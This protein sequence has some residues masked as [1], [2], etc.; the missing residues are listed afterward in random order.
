V[1]YRTCPDALKHTPGE[2]GAS[3]A[4][5]PAAPNDAATLASPGGAS[6][7]TPAEPASEGRQKRVHRTNNR[8]SKGSS[9][10]SSSRSRSSSRSSRRRGREQG[11]QQAVPLAG[12]L[13]NE[14][15]A[16]FITEALLQEIRQVSGSTSKVRPVYCFMVFTRT[17]HCR[18]SQMSHLL[19]SH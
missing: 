9:S 5:A 11:Q 15:E 7:L 13:T 8:S 1:A 2:E 18:V 6:P 16:T 17:P 19:S 12:S 3:K 4:E 10:S 14:D